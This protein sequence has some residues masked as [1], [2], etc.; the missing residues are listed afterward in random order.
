MGE[1]HAVL[2]QLLSKVNQPND[3]VDVRLG[4][5]TA[6]LTHNDTLRKTASALK[7]KG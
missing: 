1:N 3:N 4:S 7:H 6:A 2:C 5:Q